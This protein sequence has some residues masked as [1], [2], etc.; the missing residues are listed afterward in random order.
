MLFDFEWVFW[1]FDGVSS[2]D[3]VFE[4]VGDDGRVGIGVVC[5]CGVGVVFLYVYF[6]VVFVDDL[7]EFGVCLCWEVWM[8]FKFGVDDV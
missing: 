5:E 6:D 4:D 7:G 1:E 8:R 3:A 2:I